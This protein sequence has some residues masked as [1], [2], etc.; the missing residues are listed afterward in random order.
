VTGPD[1]GGTVAWWFC[2]WAILRTGGRA[3][4][5]TPS[6][7][8]SIRELGEID[9]LVLGGGADVAET[10]VPEP[11]PTLP[12]EPGVRSWWRRVISWVLAPIVFLARWIAAARPAMPEDPARDRLELSLLQHARERQLPALGICRGAQLMAVAS[13]GTL[14]RDVGR[15]FAERPDLWTVLPRRQLDVVP[16]S[17]L[18][19]VLGRASVFANSLH[20][21]AVAQVAPPLRVAARENGTG[22][23][24]AIEDP[25]AP[26]WCGV[27]WHPEYLP[28]VRRHQRLFHALVDRAR[29]AAQHRAERERSIERP[30]AGPRPWPVEDHTR[31]PAAHPVQYPATCLP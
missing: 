25:Q 4:R 30:R 19:G 12:R 7:P 8:R 2:R 9:G 20:H 17:T 6:R 16:G 27:Q 28:Q 21:D 29:T 5:I 15:H 11:L 23:V 10:P 31:I 26:F 18:H 24:Q 22:V 14:L 3:L 13:G 1:R